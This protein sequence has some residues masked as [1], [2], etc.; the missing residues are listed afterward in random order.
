MR[1]AKEVFWL[2]ERILFLSNIAGLS[3]VDQQRTSLL[4]V[5]T[6]ISRHDSF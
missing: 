6:E 2:V 4:L 1:K 3:A 5:D